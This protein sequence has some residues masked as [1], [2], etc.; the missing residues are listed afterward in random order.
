MLPAHRDRLAGNAAP[1]R[2]SAADTVTQVQMR[3]VDFYVDPDIALRIHHLRGEMRS[4]RGGPV[5]FDDKTSFIIHIDTAEVGLTGADLGALMNKYVFNYPGSPLRNLRVSMS[6]SEIVQKGTLHKVLDVPFEITASLAVT[7]DG[8]IQ[9]H[10][11]KTVI[12]GLHV[13]HLMKAL[14]LSLDKIISLSGAKG[15][16]V[17]GNDIFLN[18]TT[19]IPPPSIEGRIVAIK[20]AGDQVVQTFAPASGSPPAPLAVP[21]T[22]AP[23]YMFYKGGRLQFGKLLMLDAEM[24]IVDIDQADPFRFSLEK[25]NA[26]LIE[27]YSVTLPDLGLEVHMRDLDK[28]GKSKIS[29]TSVPAH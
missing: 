2:D 24:L 4:K 25:Y 1:P 7:P 29:V 17:K 12:L 23:N 26:Q 5:M 18:P 11:T 6:G 14:G 28:L 8:R 21:D 9:I 19:I 10:P 27:G 15:A 3:N 16:T 13:D 20:V 22:S